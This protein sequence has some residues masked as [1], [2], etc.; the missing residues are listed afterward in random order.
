ME[1]VIIFNKIC[2]PFE[3]C[4]KSDRNDVPF[5][6]RP[7]RRFSA[8]FEIKYDKCLGERNIFTQKKW[9]TGKRNTHDIINVFRKSDGLGGNFWKSGRTTDVVYWVHVT[10]FFKIENNVTVALNIYTCSW[11]SSWRVGT[12]TKLS[13]IWLSWWNSELRTKFWSENIMTRRRFEDICVKIHSFSSLTTGPK[14]LPKRTVH[15]VWSRASSF[16]WKYPLLS[17]RS[18]R[19]FRRL[20]PRLPV[21]SISH[22]IFPSITRCRRYFLRKMRPIQL[23]F[24]ENIILKSA[25]D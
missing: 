17:L 13:R 16:K 11:R 15:I 12:V 21:T 3:F 22:F 14:P 19:S 5:T 1:F 20:L 9:C 6:G 2:R 4:L 23:A 24:R 18:S 8:H 10:Q 7:C 25:F